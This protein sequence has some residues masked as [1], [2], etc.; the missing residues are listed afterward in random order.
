M[1]KTM[2]QFKNLIAEVDKLRD[3]EELLIEDFEKSTCEL[4]SVFHWIIQCALEGRNSCSLTIDTCP[5]L[6]T[7]T[8]EGMGF[9]VRENRN[10][11]EVLCGYTI[12]WE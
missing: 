3:K 1:S 10:C 8:L 11:F 12:Y 4:S 6:Y 5:T 2:L 9:E 7:K